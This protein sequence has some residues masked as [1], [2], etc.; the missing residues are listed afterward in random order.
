[1][2]NEKRI[3]AILLGLTF[4]PLVGLA[5]S[6]LNRTDTVTTYDCSGCSQ[7]EGACSK[8]ETD[9]CVCDVNCPG[10]ALACNCQTTTGTVPTRTYNG[11]SDIYTGQIEHDE[12]GAGSCTYYQPPF[13]V[14]PFYVC[15]ICDLTGSTAIPGTGSGTICTN[16]WV[17]YP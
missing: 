1:M 3:L 4:V 12:C 2:K 14:S 15:E 7:G 10:S 11:S 8:T 17:L 6:K 9:N 16:V 5:V 13:P